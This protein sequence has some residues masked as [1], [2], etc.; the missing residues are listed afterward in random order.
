[1]KD[2]SGEIINTRTELAARPFLKPGSQ[3]FTTDTSFVKRVSG[4]GWCD[5]RVI[6]DLTID[7]TNTGWVEFSVD[8]GQ[9]FIGF[10]SKDPASSVYQGIHINGSKL[11]SININR[12][13]DFRKREV[14]A[15]INKSLVRLRLSGGTLTF[16][17]NHKQIE[18]MPLLFEQ[19]C[20]LELDLFSS[21]TSIHSLRTSYNCNE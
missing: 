13:G 11:Y 10:T 1:V 20:S 8:T 5:S 15:V 16:Y 4:S 6:A 12:D 21:D 19:P 9:A 18:E 2:R 17:L 7:P 14:G 3:S